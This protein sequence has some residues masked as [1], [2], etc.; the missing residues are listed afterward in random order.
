[1]RRVLKPGGLSVYTTKNTNDPQYRTGIHRGEDMWQIE[2][3]FIVHFLSREKVEH[4]SES[5][6]WAL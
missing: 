2:G 5:K 3:G 4:L 6:I 1:M